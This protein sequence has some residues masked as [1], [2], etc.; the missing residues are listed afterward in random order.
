[1]KTI[2]QLARQFDLSRSTL[3]YYDRIGLLRPS[4]RSAAN[5]RL[6]SDADCRR[7]EKICGFRQA[8]LSL[9]AIAGLLESPHEDSLAPILEK[10]L[11]DLNRQIHALR[12]Q[13]RLI[14][15][16]LK[17]NGLPSRT[18]GLTR[19]KWVA[20]LRASGMDDRAMGR[21]HDEFERLFP[22]DHH[23]FLLS[24]GIPEADVEQ[25]RMGSR[26]R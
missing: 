9:D 22:E 17:Q 19:D 11:V 21:W 25:I 6:Y 14:M 16:L 10:R 2:S 13:Q 7:L 3:L 1:M 4:S 8:G 18:K 23:G 12:G 15:S 24:L 20:L 5:Y 26:N